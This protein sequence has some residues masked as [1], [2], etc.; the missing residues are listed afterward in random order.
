MRESMYGAPNIL[1]SNAPYPKPPDRSVCQHCKAW[2][3]RRWE[4]IQNNRR[5]SDINVSSII[6]EFFSRQHKNSCAIPAHDLIRQRYKFC[7]RQLQPNTAGTPDQQLLS[8]ELLIAGST[9]RHAPGVFPAPS[10]A[11]VKHL[12]SVHKSMRYEGGTRGAQNG[13]NLSPVV[14]KLA[15]PG[16]NRAL[17]R[18]G[19]RIV[20]VDIDNRRNPVEQEIPVPRRAAPPSEA[21][22]RAT[23]P[24]ASRACRRPMTAPRARCRIPIQA[25]F[26]RRMSTISNSV[27]S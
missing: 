23:P 4:M 5:R 27:C 12:L 11:S 1:F 6:G 9:T 7:F 13:L 18:Y 16:F 21:W 10:N 14:P 2:G 20:N 8:S 17:G 26:S 19:R 22:H 15:S 3:S 25:R 24:T